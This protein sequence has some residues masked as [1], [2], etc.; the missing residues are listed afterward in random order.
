MGTAVHGVG[1]PALD[2]VKFLGKA[3][4]LKKVVGGHFLEA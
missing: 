4:V 3:H 1:N 2:L